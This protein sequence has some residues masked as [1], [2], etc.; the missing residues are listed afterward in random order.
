MNKQ[1]LVLYTGGT[2]GMI[3]SNKGVLSPIPLS[4]LQ[5]FLPEVNQLNIRI[6]FLQHDTIKDSSD[7]SID[8]WNSIGKQIERAN[9]QYDGFIVIHGTD[10]ICY[11]AAA[12]ETIISFNQKPIILTG[13]QKPFGSYLSDA[14]DNLLGAINAA[15]LCLEANKGCIGIFF[16]GK[17]FPALTSFK[18]HRTQFDAFDTTDG[19]L[20]AQ[21]YDELELDADRLQPASASPVKFNYLLPKSIFWLSSQISGDNSTLIEMALLKEPKAIVLE[22]FGTGN[23]PLSDETIKSL[24]TFIREGNKVVITSDSPYGRININQYSNGRRLLNIGATGSGVLSKSGLYMS[25]LK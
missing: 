19:V 3:N 14:K 6:D 1:L 7:H 18:K 9:N 20:L 5:E 11:T 8:D 21:T 12:L 24:K 4:G 25:L 22:G 2:I 23:F 16:H 10:T 15:N 17:L 13:A